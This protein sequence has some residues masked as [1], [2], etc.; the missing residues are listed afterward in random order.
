MQLKHE[1]TK[2]ETRGPGTFSTQRPTI[3]TAFISALPKGL[4]RIHHSER[5][6]GVRAPE[7]ILENIGQKN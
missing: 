4:M 2:M 1:E 5:I 7:M 3:L 6:C